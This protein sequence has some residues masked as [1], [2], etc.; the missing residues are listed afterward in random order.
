MFIDLI[1]LGILFS[2]Q[3]PCHVL[4]LGIE[5]NVF[6]YELIIQ[7]N[8]KHKPNYRFFR[9]IDE[10]DNCHPRRIVGYTY[11]PVMS[12][13][14]V[15]VKSRLKRQGGGGCGKCNWIGVD[16]CWWWVVD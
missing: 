4:R 16:G 14:S 1:L 9:E 6:H 11:Q 8:V 7:Y 10:D 3:Y 15:E 5:I 13:V 12:R 2:D